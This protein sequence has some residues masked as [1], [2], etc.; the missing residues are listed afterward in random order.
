MQRNTNGFPYC[1]PDQTIDTNTTVKN[2]F[3]NSTSRK[4]II[5]KSK[6]M[7]KNKQTWDDSKQLVADVKWSKNNHEMP[8]S[9]QA[10][11]WKKMTGSGLEYQSGG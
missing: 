10:C 6:K 8:Y 9:I 7:P 4:R 11:H 3:Y 1:V 2:F 5:K